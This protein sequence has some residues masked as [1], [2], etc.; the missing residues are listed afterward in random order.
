MSTR[1]GEWNVCWSGR[2]HYFIGDKSLCG[3]K[4]DEIIH[5]EHVI[6]SCFG[7]T[8]RPHCLKCMKLNG[9]KLE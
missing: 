9:E 1:N 5:N 7:Y 6:K 4:K 8:P 2:Q 3:V